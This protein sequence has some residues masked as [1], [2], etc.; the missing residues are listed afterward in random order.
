MEERM[1][2]LHDLQLQ[3]CGEKWARSWKSLQNS[4]RSLMAKCTWHIKLIDWLLSQRVPTVEADDAMGV[5]CLSASNGLQT[6]ATT[7]D[8]VVKAFMSLAEDSALDEYFLKNIVRHIC[9]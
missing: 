3:Y 6:G 9:G 8:A 1:V 5:G 4:A 7:A 2:K